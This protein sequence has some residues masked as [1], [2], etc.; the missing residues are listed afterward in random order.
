ML[1]IFSVALVLCA[2][3]L[4]VSAAPASK[5]VDGCKA[6]SVSGG[7]NVQNAFE[8]GLCMGI[9]EAILK[10]MSLHATPT[11]HPK[12]TTRQGLQVLVKYM[13]D[14][15][16]KLHEETSFLAVKA[17]RQAWPCSHG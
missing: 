13:N 4:S 10:T 15:P 9:V 6:A 16:E 5:D 14:H 3:G 1:R 2:T 17:F 7:S 12:V 11:C 8:V